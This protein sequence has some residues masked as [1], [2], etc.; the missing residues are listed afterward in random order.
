MSDPIA[1]FNALVAEQH[2]AL[3]APALDTQGAAL[4]ELEHA[5]NRDADARVAVMRAKVTLTGHRAVLVLAGKAQGKNAEEREALLMEMTA[6]DRCVL[7]LAE[8]EAIKAKAARDIA[9]LR[10][11]A[12]LAGGQR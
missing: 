5:I 4:Q 6:A 12:A 2:A 3:N 11:D 9:Q 8:E 10:Y 7:D 1:D